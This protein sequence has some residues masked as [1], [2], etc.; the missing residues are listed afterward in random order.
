MD[1][2][3]RVLSV[4][5]RPLTE[6][7]RRYFWFR[8]HLKRMR[9]ELQQAYQNMNDQTSFLEPEFEALALHINELEDKLSFD[10]ALQK[11]AAALENDPSNPDQ[12][13]TSWIS[14]S[15]TDPY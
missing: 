2:A 6:L 4:S 5:D 3:S 7:E 15:S 9:D 13:L 11:D 1:A 10:T 14:G 8:Y 12:G